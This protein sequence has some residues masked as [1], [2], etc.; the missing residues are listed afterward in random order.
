MPDQES[1]GVV[2]LSSPPRRIRT[3]AAVVALALLVALLATQVIGLLTVSNRLQA[4]EDSFYADAEAVSEI[5]D[6]QET[7]DTQRTTYLEEILATLDV[8]QA[9]TA[10]SVFLRDFCTDP[11]QL[12]ELYQ[13]MVYDDPRVDNINHQ[14][15]AQREFRAQVLT[16]CNR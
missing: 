14:A 15:H 5:A 10:P 11:A 12:N 3:V 9:N 7:R 2:D 8:I 1:D 6:A 16:Y 13:E 4:I